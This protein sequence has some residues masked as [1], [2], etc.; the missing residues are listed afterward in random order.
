MKKQR[1]K[2]RKNSKHKENDYLVRIIS[3]QIAVCLLVF[4]TALAY[5]KLGGDSFNDIVEEYK[6]L[7]EDDM[8]IEDIQSAFSKKENE[9]ETAP[10][11]KEQPSMAAPLEDDEEGQED[12]EQTSLNDSRQLAS[13]AILS[14]MLGSKLPKNSTGSIL[15]SLLK[16]EPVLPLAST[17]ITSAFGNRT[18]PISK[19]PELHTGTDFAA[20]VGDRVRA[21]LDGEVKEAGFSNSR[22]YYLI[23]QHK[24]NMESYYYHNSKLLVKEGTVVRA[25]ESIAL[26]GSTGVSTGP[27][28]HL[29][30]HVNGKAKDPM[31]V[32]FADY[33]I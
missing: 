33:E 14:P 23:L 15:Q 25:G 20:S 17:R 2:N 30:I 7:T 5:S 6:R 8:G 13:D 16:E 28:V 29:E 4:L 11:E 19:K 21:V 22:G 12:R 18:H 10:E 31:K 27:H 24:N 1:S 32:L 26:A 3:V 9:P